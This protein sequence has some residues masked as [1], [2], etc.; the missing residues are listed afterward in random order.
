MTH[1][2]IIIV[3]HGETVWNREG[4]LQGRM[5]SPL[6]DRGRAQARL[7][8]D[9]LARDGVDQ[10]ALLSSPLGRARSTAAEIATATR[11]EYS[12]DPDLAEIGVGEW[13]GL[14]FDQIAARGGAMSDDEDHLAWCGRAPG[15][16]G[17]DAMLTRIRNV[18]ARLD[19]PTILV[20]HGLFSRV[21]RAEVLDVGTET[22]EGGQGVIYRLRGGRSE[23]ILP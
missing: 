5:D 7:M 12:L 19:G 11:L 14:T 15:G 6:T 4:R 18:L 9:W 2:E 8:G 3:R 22:L 1:P 16:E 21:L 17:I 13:E 20:C 23:R 10:H